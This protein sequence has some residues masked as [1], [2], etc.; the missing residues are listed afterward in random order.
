MDSI[1]R[2]RRGCGD[3]VRGAGE[4]FGTARRVETN[5]TLRSHG[6]PSRPAT[7][8]AHWNSDAERNPQATSPAARPREPPP[9]LPLYR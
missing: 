2:W 4:S 3:W 5:Y 6:V 8:L 1:R 7:T 9:S